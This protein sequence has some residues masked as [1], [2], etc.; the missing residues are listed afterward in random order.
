MLLY[1]LVFST[2]RTLFMRFNK[3]IGTAIA[4]AVSSAIALTGCGG[5]GSSGGKQLVR[6]SHTQIETHPDHIGLEAFKKYVES[7]L[8]D[9]FIGSAVD[10]V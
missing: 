8:A 7:K 3:L 2:E 5:D 6:M 10:T 1:S 9:K 4:A